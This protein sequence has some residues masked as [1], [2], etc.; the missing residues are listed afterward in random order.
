MNSG[1]DGY[2]IFPHLLFGFLII[3]KEGMKSYVLTPKPL[4]F[5]YLTP[6]PV[7]LPAGKTKQCQTVQWFSQR[8]E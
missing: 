7:I 1:G 3:G 4:L 2:P 5:G 8:K 6:L